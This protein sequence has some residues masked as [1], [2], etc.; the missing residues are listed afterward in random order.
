MV[1]P[2]AGAVGYLVAGP[3]G[4]VAGALANHAHAGFRRVRHVDGEERSL[5]TGRRD[6]DAAADPRR[7]H[8]PR[9]HHADERRRDEHAGSTATS[10]TVPT[11]TTATDTSATSTSAT[12]TADTATSTPATST[13]HDRP[14]ADRD[15][16]A[17]H[18]LPGAGD[19]HADTILT[20][21]THRRRRDPADRLDPSER[22][23]IALGA[24]RPAHRD[25]VHRLRRA[26]GHRARAGD[27]PRVGAV[28]VAR[29]CR[30]HPAGEQRDRPGA[31]R[32]DHR[33]GRRGAGA[34]ASRPTTSWPIPYLIKNAVS[35]S[36]ELSSALGMP[37]LTVL[38]RITKPHTGFVYLAHLV[39]SGQAAAIAEPAHRRHQ[40]GSRRRAGCIR[41]ATRPR[42]WS[43]RSIG[44]GTG[45]S[46]IEYQYNNVLR[47]HQRPA[48]DRQR[49]DGPA[50]LDRR[51]AAR[52]IPARPSR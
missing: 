36:A 35:A 4:N 39:P 48:P 32:R 42:R 47:G 51:P 14:A 24:H 29:A 30:G 52:P 44:D 7:A 10:G 28:R 15:T 5:V 46:G 31:A 2:P 13:A 17:D 40:P 38:G 18:H 12:S 1:L 6:F 33:S 11:S 20:G 8:A 22:R 27:V 34:S 37:R 21:A 3:D 16:A 49:R 41:A 25:P 50:D 43:A 26:A 9:D 45:A 19:E 23:G